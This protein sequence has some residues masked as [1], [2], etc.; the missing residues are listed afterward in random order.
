MR[1]K[2]VIIATTVFLGVVCGVM[3][4]NNQSHYSS[5]AV[6]A[7]ISNHGSSEA[8]IAEL[9]NDGSFVAYSYIPVSKES[10]KTFFQKVV[11]WFYDFRT[12]WKMTNTLY[13][14][15]DSGLEDF[16]IIILHE[17]NN[18]TYE[19]TIEPT[20]GAMEDALDLQSKLSKAFP[21]LPCKI[22]GSK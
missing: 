2:W 18:R 11:N 17:K 1:K 9:S 20:K 6:I 21:D 13:Y 4:L 12:N 3:I 8:V 5:E 7:E 10:H 22:T 19:V 16:A 14:Y 15:N